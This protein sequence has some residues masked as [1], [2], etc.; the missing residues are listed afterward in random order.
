MLSIFALPANARHHDV[1]VAFHTSNIHHTQKPFHSLANMMI[2]SILILLAM[3]S[4]VLAFAPISSSFKKCSLASALD[5]AT[6]RFDSTKQRWYINPE[7][8]GAESGYDANGSL[9]R[10]GPKAY[11]T[12]ILNPDEYEQACLKFMAQ[13]GCT[14]QQAQGNM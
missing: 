6:P 10:Q 2:R 11:L 12:R 7:S 5:M 13:D 8:E 4:V 9:L 14:Y 1:A 3:S